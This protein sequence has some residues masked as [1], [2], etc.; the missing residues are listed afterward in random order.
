M[1]TQTLY[2]RL[3][4]LGACSEAL[5]WLAEQEGIWD[6]SDIWPAYQACRRDPW[7][8]W[9]LYTL[10]AEGNLTYEEVNLCTTATLFPQERLEQ[11]WD[12]YWRHKV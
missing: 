9:L 3:H 1:G 11:A 10:C 12:D 2:D 7:R 5:I 6:T 4:R 8:W